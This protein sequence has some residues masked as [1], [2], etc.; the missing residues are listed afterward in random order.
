M[1]IIFK[2]KCE[3]CACGQYGLCEK[4]YDTYSEDCEFEL[5]VEIGLSIRNGRF[6]ELTEEEC[7]NREVGINLDDYIFEERIETR[8]SYDMTG[9]GDCVRRIGFLR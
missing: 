3:Q 4:G 8:E 5:D 6:G 2:T 7:V 9:N 1:T